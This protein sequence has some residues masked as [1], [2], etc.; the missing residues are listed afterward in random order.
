MP[1]T[2]KGLAKLIE[3]CAELQVVAAKKLAYYT[4]DV[5]PDGAGS[6]KGRLEDEIADVI[7]ACGLVVDLHGLDV[8]RI[9]E[10]SDV[11]EATFKAWQADPKNNESAIDAPDRAVVEVAREAYKR[12]MV[13][14]EAF[15][16]RSASK[17]LMP[18]SPDAEASFWRGAAYGAEVGGTQMLRAA[19]EHVPTS[20]IETAAQAYIDALDGGDPLNCKLSIAERGLRSAL[21]SAR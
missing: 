4:T 2:A 11:K 19:A 13:E 10:R 16:D 15:K 12:T 3:E 18:L 7:A 21:R 5:H 8:D 20:S 6:L 1:M 17:V 9:A 14:I